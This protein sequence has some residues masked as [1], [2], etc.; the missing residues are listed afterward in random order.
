MPDDLTVSNLVFTF[1]EKSPNTETSRP[2]G[3]EKFWIISRT[4]L[5][6]SKT[7][8]SAVFVIDILTAFFPLNLP[9]EFSSSNL[10]SIEATSLSRSCPPISLF[11]S[12]I[13][14][15]GFID[16]EPKPL[17]RIS[18]SIAFWPPG[19]PDVTS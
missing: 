2:D 1:F 9:T 13:F 8:A 10:C 19:S 15:I 16:D 12:V 3:R 11:L 14:S 6:T 17:K 18:P 7:E 5:D 4:P